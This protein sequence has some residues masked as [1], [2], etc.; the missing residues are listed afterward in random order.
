MKKQLLYMM[1]LAGMTA[2]T[3]EDSIVQEQQ[4]AA[5]AQVYQVSIPATISVGA[6]TRAIE[7]G[8]DDKEGWLVSKF[9]KDVDDI[10]VYHITNEIFANDATAD[11]D[12][13][14]LLH[15]DQN[16]V[17]ANLTGSLKFYQGETD[18]GVTVGDRLLLLYG[19]P[20]GG[21]GWNSQIG[22]FSNLS[23]YDQATA[24]VEVTAIDGNATD[25]YT[26]TTTKA[27]FENAQSM[28]KFTF[29]GLPEGVGVK[30]VTI[31]SA[32]KKLVTN[33]FPQSN[34]QYSY[35]D[36][37]IDLL[38]DDIR[39]VN[40]PGVVYTALCFMPMAD[41]NATD[42]IT[43]TVVGTDN[44]TYTATKASP[45]GGFQNGKYY[46]STIALTTCYV[47]GKYNLANATCN[48]VALNGAELTGTMTGHTLFIADGATVTLSG[49][50][51]TAAEGDN[52]GPIRC[53]GDATIILADGTE[54]V[55][56]SSY[57]N[58]YSAVHWPAGKTLTI[59][60]GTA[61]TGKLTANCNYVNS[62]DSRAGIGSGLNH[63]CGNL[64]ITGGIITAYGA[65]SGAGIGAACLGDCGDIT[66]SGGTVTA[67][68]GNG[69][70][71]GAGEGS[72]SA[73][74]G[75]IL[76][77]GGIVTATGGS[78]KAAGIGHG[79]NYNS[80]GSVTITS[81][82][83]SVTATRR[84]DNSSV[85]CIGHCYGS[86][87]RATIDGKTIDSQ[88]FEDSFDVNYFPTFE[89]LTLTVSGGSDD[90]D[91]KGARTWTLTRKQQ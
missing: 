38:D 62:G 76:I 31:H 47:E 70:G 57:A 29:T 89:H 19:T 59:K 61:G 75:K 39:T 33:Y 25:G 1:V 58:D 44:K 69:A 4:P 24:T 51:V 8:T 63:P 54:N 55:A 77:S 21:F 83:T 71:I 2:C 74:C 23:A 9:I 82:I 20:T 78:S 90:N 81:G 56:N 65:N 3:N 88:Y 80:A 27:N 26:L 43:F 49:A 64:E 85:R 66:I 72:G 11:E 35:G 7:E 67:T 42:D 46:T 30:E 13:L 45:K 6:Q 68:G 34:P 87:S 17:T 22:N 52:Y 37:M 84:S 28:F 18:L 41:A 15:P 36:I 91:Y 12:P 86:N 79:D 48:I 50:S 73:K 10:S 32:Q 40:G 60:G 5:R 16:G 14:T 53:L